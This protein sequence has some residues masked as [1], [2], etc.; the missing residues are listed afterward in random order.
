MPEMWEQESDPST[1]SRSRCD[2][3]KELSVAHDHAHCGLPL[4]L[5]DWYPVLFADCFGTLGNT[6]LSRHRCQTGFNFVLIDRIWEA[7]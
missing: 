4:S 6:H 2:I 1:W 7:E 5:C 3:Q